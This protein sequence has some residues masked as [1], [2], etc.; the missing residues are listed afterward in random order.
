MTMKTSDEAPTEV[1]SVVVR[2]YNA[3]VIACLAEQLDPAEY[4]QFKA[5]LTMCGL[6]FVAQRAAREMQAVFGSPDEPPGDP[7]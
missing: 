3:F 6:G 7:T 2:D 1:V 4:L 5:L